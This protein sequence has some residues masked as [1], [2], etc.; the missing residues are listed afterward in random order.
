MN[1]VILVARTTN[2]IE[3]RDT[4]TGKHYARFGLAL[5]KADDSCDFIN[6]QAWGKVAEFAENY[7]KD[8]GTRICVEGRLTTYKDK[9]NNTRVE[10][11]ADHIEFADGRKQ[12]EE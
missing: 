2:N 4:S 3:G 7:I 12:P 11:I 6:C 5:P 1:R 10:V 9:N 8:K